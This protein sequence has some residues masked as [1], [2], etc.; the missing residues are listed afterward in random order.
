MLVFLSN[1]LPVLLT[2]M[3]A[4][5][6]CIFN[7]LM[8]Q[9]MVPVVSLKAHIPPLVHPLNLLIFVQPKCTVSFQLYFKHLD[10]PHLVLPHIRRCV[11]FMLFNY[12]RMGFSV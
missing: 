12:G 7:V 3:I 4:L 6:L 1:Y 10:T 9:K 8:L 2:F 11:F 5:L